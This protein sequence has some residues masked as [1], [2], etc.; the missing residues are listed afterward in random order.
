MWLKL[1]QFVSRK[2]IA[3]QWGGVCFSFFLVFGSLSPFFFC[4][5][6]RIKWMNH[7]E[8]K[9]YKIKRY[10]A[11]TVFSFYSEEFSYICFRSQTFLFDDTVWNDFIVSF[12]LLLLL[13]NRRQIII[14]NIQTNQWV[15]WH[16]LKETNLHRMYENQIRRQIVFS[17]TDHM[18]CCWQNERHRGKK[19]TN[20]QNKK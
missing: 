7:G 20:R 4:T 13:W 15:F 3:I 1:G 18:N 9:K 14:W 5:I 2:V 6:D 16:C 10:V 11:R 17:W 12:F 19:K 8:C